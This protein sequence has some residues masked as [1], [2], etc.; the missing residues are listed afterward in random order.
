MQMTYVG[1]TLFVNL[2]GNVDIK[3]FKRK[4][5]SII[6]IYHI[7]NVVVSIRNVF[8]YKRKDYNDIKSDY[9]KIYNGK[10]TLKKY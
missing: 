6:S 8:N 1:D 4:L 3:I 7:E 5:F 9:K 10:F 2:N